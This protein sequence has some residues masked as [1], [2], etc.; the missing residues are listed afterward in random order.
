MR[1]YRQHNTGD[2]TVK[3][4]ASYRSVR[5]R[6]EQCELDMEL[7]SVSLE[8]SDC[9]AEGGVKRRSAKCLNSGAVMQWVG[10]VPFLVVKIFTTQINTNLALSKC[11]DDRL[12][13]TIRPKTH[14]YIRY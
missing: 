3:E 11:A 7:V 6:E 2:D 5:E 1:D 8:H 12:S 4:L 9:V 13:C 10:A 14:Q